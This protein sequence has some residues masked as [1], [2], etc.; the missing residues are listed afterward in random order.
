MEEAVAEPA[1]SPKHQ[2]AEHAQTT[3]LPVPKIATQTRV[4]RWPPAPGGAKG[5]LS[6]SANALHPAQSSPFIAS[7]SSPALATAPSNA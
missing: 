4:E 6:P 7:P 3:V 5:S 1:F 2:E